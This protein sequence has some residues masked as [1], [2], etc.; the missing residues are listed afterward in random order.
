MRFL[1]AS[2]DT[3]S[4]HAAVGIIPACAQTSRTVK[5]SGFGVAT[6]GV[7]SLSIISKKMVPAVGTNE[8]YT[9]IMI[10]IAKP[11]GSDIIIPPTSSPSIVET[12]T[13]PVFHENGFDGWCIPCDWESQVDLVV[14]EPLQLA[15]WNTIRNRLTISD[16]DGRGSRLCSRL[17]EFSNLSLVIFPF[18]QDCIGLGEFKRGQFQPHRS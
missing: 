1:S 9:G 5:E 10:Q 4:V 11:N 8:V 18:R 15:N 3:V 7:S 14:G 13:G 17:S 16:G 6:K 2:V 12:K